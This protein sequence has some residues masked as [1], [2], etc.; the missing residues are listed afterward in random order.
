MKIKLIF[1]LLLIFIKIN[2]NS[3]WQWRQ[4]IK[5]EIKPN[6]YAL[7][8]KKLEKIKLDLTKLKISPFNRAATNFKSGFKISNYSFVTQK[9]FLRTKF[10]NHSWHWWW[11]NNKTAFVILFPLYFKNKY[12]YYPPIYYDFYSAYG[13][14]PDN[15]YFDIYLN[16]YI[17]SYQNRLTSLQR[18][19]KYK[20]R[21]Q[22][23][24]NCL[25]FCV[26]DLY[27]KILN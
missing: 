10:K 20:P 11:N 26:N 25:N 13:Y 2:S 7:I 15:E 21:C 19:S 9:K 22:N 5:K 6:I 12:N 1:V 24:E 17:G 27:K 14:Y 18:N 16:K 23:L 8:N 3:L 4:Q